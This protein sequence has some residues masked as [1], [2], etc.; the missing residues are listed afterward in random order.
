MLVITLMLADVDGKTYEYGMLRVFGFRMRDLTLMIS[1]NSTF[2][3]LPGLCLGLIL[4]FL[5]NVA[6]REVIF[7]QASNWLTYDLTKSALILGITCGF[8]VPLL[9]NYLPVRAALS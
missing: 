5:I 2:F 6:L 1:L 9:A 8:L 3:S 7:L 4:A